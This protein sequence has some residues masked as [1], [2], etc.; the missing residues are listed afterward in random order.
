MA[1]DT[2][3]DSS[4]EFVDVP[5]EGQ[6]AKGTTKQVIAKKKR[7]KKATDEKT[8]NKVHSVTY[9]VRR[10]DVQVD[11]EMLKE[12]AR[13]LGISVSKYIR[14]LQYKDWTARGLRTV[15]G[16]PDLEALE[17]LKK[18]NRTEAQS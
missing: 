14:S 4:Q 18:A 13:S 17:N 16:N 12:V 1:S 3:V 5:V 7:G 2:V 8:V 9:Y 15:E 6:M 11:L 10:K